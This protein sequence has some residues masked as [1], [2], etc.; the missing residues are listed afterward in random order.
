MTG[1]IECVSQPSTNPVPGRL[2]TQG[3]VSALLRNDFMAFIRKTFMTLNPGA[4]FCDNWHI[5]AIAHHL[6][7]VRLGTIKRLIITMPPRSLKSISA[8][9]AFPAFIHG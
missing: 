4:A 7:L 2:R 1:F 6:E 5:N 9:I 8:S 3:L